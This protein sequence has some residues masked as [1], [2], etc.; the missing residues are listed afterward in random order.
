MKWLLIL[1]LLQTAPPPPPRLAISLTPSHTILIDRLP[2]EATSACLV[3]KSEDEV[4]ADGTP[5]APRH[6]VWFEG[7]AE[8]YQEDWDFITKGHNYEMWVE[9]YLDPDITLESNHLHEAH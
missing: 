9:V 6:C 7:P 1:S 4:L 8:N 3:F 2:P 5:W